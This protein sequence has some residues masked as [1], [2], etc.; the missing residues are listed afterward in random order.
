VPTPAPALSVVATPSVGS[1]TTKTSGHPA[2]PCHPKS[3]N[4]ESASGYSLPLYSPRIREEVF[5][6]TQHSLGP[7]IEACDRGAREGPEPRRT[8]ALQLP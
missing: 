4:R 2:P 5:S 1:P 3:V 7:P 6:E 8:P